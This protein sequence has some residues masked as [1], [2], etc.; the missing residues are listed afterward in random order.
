[1]TGLSLW[2]PW[3]SLYVLH[4]KH[5][6]TRDWALRHRGWLL[7]HAAKHFTRDER[8]LCAREPFKAALAAH[9]YD[10]PAQLPLGA[11]VGAVHIAECFRIDA[12]TGGRITRKEYA[13]GNYA[14]G[15]YGFAADRALVLV[16]PLPWTG[17]QGLFNIDLSL[18]ETDRILYDDGGRTY[19]LRVPVS[20]PPL[21]GDLGGCV[22][23][24]GATQ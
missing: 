14:P 18:D 10:D 1:M 8:E 20:S 6:E 4:E 12:H 24:T 21:K 7:I 2:Q 13:F 9:G 17:K 16:T 23:K 15:R 5:N 19:Q 3:A 22:A 11:I